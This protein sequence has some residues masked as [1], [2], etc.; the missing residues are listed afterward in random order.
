MAGRTLAIGDIHGCG[1]TFARLLDKI[2][3]SR[4]D[5][6]Y[7][8]G[9]LID[10]GPDSKLV[11]QTILTLIGDGYDIR[12]VKGNHE[13]M[14]L[15]AEQSGIFEEL[16]DWLENGGDATLR[17]YEIEHP[18]DIPQNHLL[19]LENLPLY[20]VTEDFV[21]VHAGIDCTLGDPFS[22]SGRHHMLWDRSGIVNI[23]KLG[24]RRVVSGHSTRTLDDIRKSLRKN[25]LRIDNG[26]YLKGFVGKGNLVCIDLDSMTLIAQ[27]C[28]DD[29]PDYE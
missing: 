13:A 9:D 19:Y 27:P 8:L 26:A 16:L 2:R 28:V 15:Q 10:R 20:R 21:L 29:I 22:A 23:A 12:P 24:G 11:I 18:S 3:L 5:R 17:S 1:Q 25:H 4:T 7:L 14:L 6:L